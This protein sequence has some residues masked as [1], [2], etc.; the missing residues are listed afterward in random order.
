[1][2][3]TPNGYS[4]VAEDYARNIFDELAQ[5]PLDR[6][7]LDRFAD[8]VRGKGPACDLGC[9]PGQIARYLKDRGVDAL[10]VDLAPGMVEQARKLNP[11]IPFYVGNMA[12]LDFPEGAWAGIAAF[13]SI[14][15]I[16]RPDVTAALVELKRVLQPGG[17]LL[18]TFHI[19]DEVVHI[20]EWW[21]KPVSLDFVFFQPDEMKGYLE[22]AGFEHIEVIERDPYAPDVEHQSRRA[23]LFARKPGS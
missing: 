5:K 1:M 15:H 19:G 21:E 10:G 8:Q 9:G 17:L 23:Y 22:S 7:L 16:P 12:A 6:Q 11:D 4:A 3:D 14:I 18:V 2:T 13:Y 20:D